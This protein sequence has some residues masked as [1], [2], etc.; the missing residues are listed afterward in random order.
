MDNTIIENGVKLDNQIQIAHNVQ[1]G[2]NTAIAACSAIA[3]STVVGKRCMIAGAV[4]V[5]GHLTITDDVH[6]TAM[7][8][9]TKSIAK[10]GSYS[11]GTPSLS[12]SAGAVS[13]KIATLAKLKA[14]SVSSSSLPPKRISV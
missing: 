3:G 4:G 10:S 7:S 1:I 11:S 8:L 9:V 6:I 5:V 2:E 13:L 12:E 14:A